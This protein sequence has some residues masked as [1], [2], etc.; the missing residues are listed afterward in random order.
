MACQKVCK[1]GRDDACMKAKV[2]ILAK[3]H[4]S[5]HFFHMQFDSILE[6]LIC[7]HPCSYSAVHKYLSFT[8]YY[9]QSA[10]Q[11]SSGYAWGF[12]NMLTFAFMSPFDS[13]NIEVDERVLIAHCAT[14]LRS[15]ILL[16]GEC[17]CVLRASW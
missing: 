2:N 16:G 12:A 9:D 14:T 17:A 4:A 5:L 1:Q 15:C 3:P 7:S 6:T 13:L 11:S 10:A 8:H